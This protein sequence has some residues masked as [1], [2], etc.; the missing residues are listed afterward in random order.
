M[1][2]NQTNYWHKVYEEQLKMKERTAVDRAF[3]AA[4]KELR[5][6]GFTT[7]GDDRAEELVA[8]IVKYVVTCRSQ[9]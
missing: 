9:L 8:A 6:G 4:N 3:T 7:C 1:L 5:A 2:D